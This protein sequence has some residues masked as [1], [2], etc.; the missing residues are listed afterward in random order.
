[1]G[2]RDRIASVLA[3]KTLPVTVVTI[4]VYAAIY[5]AIAVLDDL[6]SVPTPNK[7]LGLNVDTAYDDLHKI[8]G[9]PHPYNSHQNDVVRDYILER[10]QAAAEHSSFTTVDDDLVSNAT[11]G[12]TDIAAYFE[13][14]NV[15]VK[16]DGTQPELDGVLFS[17]HFDSVP[18]APGATDDGMG[19]ATLLSLVDYFSEHQ[20]KRTV[21]FNINDGEEDGLYGAH[22]FLEHPWFNLTSDF[23]NLEGAGAGGRP[24]LLR[25]SSTR[26]A[27]SWTNVKHPHAAVLSADAFNRGVVRSGTDY[28]V[29]TKAGRGGI[30]FSFYRQRSKY[31]TKEDSIPSIGGKAALWNMMESTLLAGL[32]LVNDE[33]SGS[34]SKGTPV[35]FDLFGEAI[36]V[37]SLKTFYIIDVALLAVG[38]LVVAALTFIAYKQEKLYWSPRGWGRTF[39]AIIVGGGL[40]I[41]LG[42]I[43]ARVNPFIVYSSATVVFASL[44]TLSLLS[45][46]IVLELFSYFLPVPQQKSMSLVEV[47]IFW[48]ILLVI[49]TVFAGRSHIAGLYF[50]TFFH[51]GALAAL[52]VDFIEHFTLPSALGRS[53]R[54]ATAAMNDEEEEVGG[55]EE[56]NER[57]PLL[58]QNGRA[59]KKSDI[60]EGNVIGLWLVQYL[61]IVPFPVILVTQI[62]VMMLNALNQ[63]LVDGSPVRTVYLAVSLLSILSFIP[64]L[65]F[66]HK[67]HRT[68]P[69]VLVVVLAATILYNVFAFPFS[70]N[71]P[72]KVFFQQTIDLDSGK[73]AVRL[74]GA[75]PWLSRRIVLELPSSWDAKDPCGHRDDLRYLMP[76]CVWPGL[77]PHVSASSP[78][79]WL[80]VNSSETAPG[81]GTLSISGL[82]SRACRVYFDK[83]I[84]TVSVQGSSGAIQEEFPLPEDGIR[85]I[86]LWSRT[87]ERTFDVSVAWDVRS[88]ED[89]EAQ[90][91][92][93]RVA[94]EWSEDAALPALQEVVNFLPKWARVTKRTDGLLEGYKKF[95]L[96]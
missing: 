17:A 80:S 29:Y 71:S 22:A 87:W 52:L 6:P 67:L 45:T 47:Y 96:G 57:T 92:T 83:P 36:I 18:T 40:T 13:G 94:C 31:H 27:Q 65:P 21:V 66:V 91:L 24:L 75:E 49:A 74:T 76:S 42:M 4:I 41:S 28:T 14:L 72:F 43:F 63:T 23:I 3:F 56:S 81:I 88:D 39:A 85:E 44:L 54:R 15:L 7:Q 55:A 79:E 30:D 8:A 70:E 64:L 84:Q 73:N 58:A 61:L 50:V 11:F 9:L 62:A 32:A 26:I 68:V 46:Y 5:I 19:T 34:G 95:S 89:K 90:S 77:E 16:V 51:A 10:V 78:S 2:I 82:E 1:M 69:Y 33:G 37:T 53:S 60:D 20:P 25:S 86:R 38:P 59:I 35:Y 12:N 48:W 93:G